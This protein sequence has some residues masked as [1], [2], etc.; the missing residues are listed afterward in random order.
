MNSADRTAQLTAV[1]GRDGETKRR[2]ALAAVA[3]LECSGRRTTFSGVA[4]A[5]SVSAWFVYNQLEV[6]AAIS[7][8]IHR[9]VHDGIAEPS[10]AL[11]PISRD[12][13]RTELLAARAEIRALRDERSTMRT[14]LQEQLGA[15]LDHGTRAE[16][17]ERLQH[18]EQRNVTL[19][20]E[21][22]RLQR[23]TDDLTA[24]AAETGVELD[25]ARA[26]YRRLMR[27]H[28]LNA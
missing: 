1:R 8:A 27:E 10:A 3:D 2:R 22:E 11:A 23:Q 18:L 13:L 19:I 5:A 16:L 24:L 6:R 14:R 9:Q 25:G 7:A 15:E 21:N 20:T 12:G 28:N 17:T 26:A 4:R